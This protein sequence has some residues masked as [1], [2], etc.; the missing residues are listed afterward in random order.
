MSSLTLDKW[1]EHGPSEKDQGY[2]LQPP[3]WIRL[4]FGEFGLPKPRL[5]Y[6]G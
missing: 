5:C 1:N 4:V 6:E 3:V 2:T